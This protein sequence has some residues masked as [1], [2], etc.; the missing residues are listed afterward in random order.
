MKRLACAA[1]ALMLSACAQA[2]L[3]STGDLGVVV[4]RA[5]GAVRLA[6]VQRPGK[7]PVDGEAFLRGFPLALGQAVG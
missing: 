2:P 7:A 6:R 1:F 4:E 3:R 5:D